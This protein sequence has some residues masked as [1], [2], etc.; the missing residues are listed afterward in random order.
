[1]D[2]RSYFRASSPSPVAS[3]S[4]HRTNESSSSDSDSDT[5]EPAPKKISLCREKSR[6][7]TSKRKYSKSWEKDFNWLLYDEDID[8][9]FCQVCKQTTADSHT[10]HTGGVWISKPF[11]NW[12]KAVEK[13]KAYERSAL[14]IKASQARL[15]TS[16][17][18]SVVQQLQRVGAIEREK[19]R[20]AMKSLA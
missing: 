18:G 1:M 5:A 14:H 11:R 13:M 8:G 10:Q 16:K 7:L 6:P 9:G 17:Q 12:K 15:L 20:A 4:S 19:N 2:I 3:S